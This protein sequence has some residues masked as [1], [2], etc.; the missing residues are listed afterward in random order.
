MP[1][2]AGLTRPG[3]TSVPAVLFSMTAPAKVL[4]ANKEKKRKA[5]HVA[6]RCSLPWTQFCTVILRGCTFSC[7]GTVI[8]STPS[9]PR[10]LMASVSAVSGRLKRR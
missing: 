9:L 7:L 4:A 10:A 3:L 8:S 2:F 1:A 6:L 5:T